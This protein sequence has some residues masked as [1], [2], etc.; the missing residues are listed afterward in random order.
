MYIKKAAYAII[1]FV[2]LAASSLSLAYP[3]NMTPLPDEP[4]FPNVVKVVY[5][6]DMTTPED[7]ARMGGLF[8]RGVNLETP[9]DEDLDTSLYRHADGINTGTSHNAS[10]YVGTTTSLG[11]ARRWVNDNLNHN[12][13]VYYIAS[14]ANF[15]PVND[16]LRVHSPHPWELEYAAMR[17]IRYDQI[18]GWRR[19]TSEIG[20][21]IPNPAYRAALFNS[22]THPA[23]VDGDNDP[24][25][26]LA[27]FDANSLWWGESPWVNFAT[28]EHRSSCSPKQSNEHAAQ[29]YWKKYREEQQAGA[30]KKVAIF[31]RSYNFGLG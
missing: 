10:G 12:G 24:L 27:G 9:S 5:R 26:A 21:F 30:R 7:A 2:S 28:C 8:A 17:Q 25:L 29:D 19:S 1:A 15:I 16:V 4:N 31:H 22:P 14:S 20:P 11:L 23:Q 3:L 18:L 13:Y 6:A